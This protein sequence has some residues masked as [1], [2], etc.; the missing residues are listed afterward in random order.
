MLKKLKNL[1]TFSRNIIIVFIGTSLVNFFN[2]LYQLL[3]A[4]KL[5]P[6]E[7]AEV[8]SLF[9]IFMVI[10]S[11]LGTIQV[12]VAKYS[13]EFNAHS[14]TAKLK[15][16]LSDL[17]HKSSILAIFTLLI[18][19]FSA[20]HITKLLKIPSLTSGYIL[21]LLLA[22]CWL[23]PV[24]AG[25]V[26][27]LELFGWLTLSSVVTGALKLVLAFS[28]LL[29]GYNISGALGA[30]L[31][32]S[33]IALVI[34]Y[35]PLKKFI[36]LKAKKEDINYRQILIYLFPVAISTFCYMSLVNMDMVLVKYFFKPQDS[37]IY[38]LA[39]MA[40][41]IFLFLPVAIS[42]V[43]FPRSSGLNAKNLDTLSTLKRSLLYASI[44][45]IIASLIYNL[46]PYFIM[47][48]LTG[49]AFLDS[50]IL[51]RFFSISMIFFAL[52]F[53]LITYFLSIKDWRF[54]KYL[55]LFTILEFLAIALFHSN[56]IQIQLI[57]SI[58]AILL[59]LIHLALAYR[60]TVTATA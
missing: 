16:L 13:A 57:L 55:V 60:K 14:Q 40:G 28:A 38:S 45:C 34:F 4:H 8:N 31:V 20:T 27:G 25:G 33:L 52:L 29:L 58:N 37:G 15:F 12:A 41:K 11:S 35:F 7:F 43:M 9:S 46:F 59:F 10:S 19:W 2:L 44:L 22:L 5:S 36:S 56:L 51:G 21:A 18:F 42:I 3:I 48:V 26:Q 54:I 30:L 6:P 1:D 50:I 32:S 39:Q 23:T 24:L 47:K 53:I 17:F 49:K